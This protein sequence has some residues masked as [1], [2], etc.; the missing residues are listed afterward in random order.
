MDLDESG[1]EFHSGV[2]F[3]SGI[4]VDTDAGATYAPPAYSDDPLPDR[5]L[6]VVH[7]GQSMVRAGIEQWL[8][9]LIR[10]LDPRRVQIVRCVATAPIHIDPGVVAEI[11]VPIDVGQEASVQRAARDCDIMLCWGPHELGSWIA[12]CRPELC[13]FIAHGEG[14][15]TR[16]ILDGCAPVVD[17]VVAVSQ[18]VW[19]RNCRDFPSTVIPNGVDSAHLARSCSRAE[20]RRSLGFGPDDF[21]L[22]MIGRFSP[23]KR[24]EV[25]I[26]AVARLPHRFKALLVGWGSL[27]HDLLERA[28]RLIPGRFAFA[29]ANGPVGDYYQ[30]LDALCMPSEE[31]GFGLV[32]LEAMMCER[33]VIATEVGCIPEFIRDR[34]SGILVSGTVN[35]VRDA[36]DLLQR[37]P[38]WA[39]G[40]AAEAKSI[41]EEHGHA[42]VMARRYERLLTRL[43][44]EKRN[45]TATVA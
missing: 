17:H 25:V 32:A 27:Y 35:S 23:E 10:F 5:P 36:A 29:T 13:V 26:D 9:G 18:R 45:G 42:R 15:W 4:K 12:D 37:F 14:P 2:R 38:A 6:R 22:G 8:K 20:I 39:K 11:G 21:V 16:W 24:P 31:E 28:N 34:I 3:F 7:V 30:A 41:A 44:H 19:E 1:V 43:Y 33:P 40:M